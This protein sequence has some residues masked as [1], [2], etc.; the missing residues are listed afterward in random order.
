MTDLVDEMD[1]MDERLSAAGRLWQA[2]QP[3]ASAVPLER[4]QE[5]RTRALSWR[6]LLAAAAVVVLVG[7]GAV[8]VTRAVGGGS[9]GGPGG[10]GTSPTPGVH[11]A[12]QVVPWRDL[13]AGHPRIG[14]RVNGKLV[15]KYDHVIAT[16]LISGHEQ[17]G[18]TLE[19]VA[20]LE[21]TTDVALDPCPDFSIAFG[22]HSWNTWQLN[23]NQVPYR[24]GHGR[25]LLPAL[26]QVR[27]QMKV[28]VP[29]EP[30][31]QKVLWTLDGPQEMPG[32]YGLVDVS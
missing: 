16:G 1:E 26:R 14:H 9:A 2:G 25:P 24:D 31:R 8:A 17:P 10:S 19:F 6:A 7:G 20:I 18:D 15:T 4:L 12:P 11:R 27:F 21:S 23:C 13:R 30:G 29:D 32:F 22:R 28:T 5:P 3:P